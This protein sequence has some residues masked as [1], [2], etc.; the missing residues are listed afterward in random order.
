MLYRLIPL[1]ILLFG[2]ALALLFWPP[3]QDPQATKLGLPP[4][5]WPKDNPY[6]PEKAALG[7]LLYFDKRLSADGTVSCATCHTIHD[8]F[9]DHLPVSTG[10]LKRQGTRN[11]PTVI[12]A[13]YQNSLFWD[14]RAASLE[15]QAKGPIAN[16]KEMSISDDE[17]QAHRACEER[18]AKIPGYRALFQKAFGHATCSIDDIAKAIATFE[19]TVIS[20]NSPYDRYEAGD[21]TALTEE[22]IHGKKIF[23][24]V[25]CA[26]CHTPP[27][28]IDGRYH[29]IGV[30]MD[31]KDPDLGRY[32][33]TH[34][35][36][37]WAAFKTPTLREVENTYPYMHDGKLWT[38]EA[39]V[40][41]YDQ[42]GI[43]SHNLHPLMKPL[44]L[45]SEEKKALV[46][47][48]RS[49]SG[50]GWQHFTEPSSF[51]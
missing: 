35:D 44:H 25:G 33:I 20:G 38:L 8:A 3:Q 32:L 15:A 48:L 18:I 7:R 49:L 47:F 40:D 39:V 45:S 36:K 17:H 16:F 37:D 13:G 46:S 5:P 12:N 27:L 41:F 10:I 2:I 6:T 34:N 42:G 21:K 23:H 24:K 11:A 51:P 1:W 31:S 14:G 4:M 22:Q 29:N 43:P 26:N 19:R 50:E 28:F 9:T 30:G